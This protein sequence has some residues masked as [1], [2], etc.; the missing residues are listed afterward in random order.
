MAFRPPPL[1]IIDEAQ[2][3]SPQVLEEVRLLTNLE[4]PKSKLLQV[5]LVGQPELEQ[6]LLRYELRQ[7]RQRIAADDLNELHAR[8][9]AWFTEAGLIDEAI[10]HA[11]AGQDIRAAT[12]LVI[13]HRYD[14]MN[15]SQFTRLSGWLR[16]LPAKTVAETPLLVSAGAFIGIE[17]GQDAEVYRCVERAD[18]LLK[19]LPPESDDYPVLAIEVLA[20]RSFIDM[21]WGR[22]EA[23]LSGASQALATLPAGALLIRSLTFFSLAFCHQ[24]AGDAKRAARVITEALSDAE[25][26]ANIR[27]RM[28]F[29]AAAIS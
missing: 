4:G 13:E 25:W 26:P 12:R 15:A 5:I 27:A 29:Y 21:A 3:L 10:Q 18:R 11:L 2:N 9:S 14:L 20:L 6:T 8:A 7:L 24:M 23:G 28:H 16:S 19:E 22:T 17:Q 1:L